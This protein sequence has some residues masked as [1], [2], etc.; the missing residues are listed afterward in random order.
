MRGGA[1]PRNTAAIAM[2]LRGFATTQTA[3]ARAALA[4]RPFPGSAKP[5]SLWVGVK[6]GDFFALALACTP[7]QA[8]FHPFEPIPIALQR[9][10]VEIL[11]TF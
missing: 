4:G 5:L 11:N 9:R 3:P 7:V 2:L 10:C 6:S 1:Q 8:A